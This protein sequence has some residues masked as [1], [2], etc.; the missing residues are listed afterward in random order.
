MVTTIDINPIEQDW[1]QL[2]WAKCSNKFLQLYSGMSIAQKL[3]VTNLE[4]VKIK[5]RQF[6]FFEY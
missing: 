6:S 2:T 5:F 4:V 3:K 1:K